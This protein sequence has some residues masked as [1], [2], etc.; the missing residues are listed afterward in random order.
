MRSI[1]LISLA[2]LGLVPASALAQQ[3]AAPQQPEAAPADSIVYSQSDSIPNF[4]DDA[5]M[6]DEFVVVTRKK[7]VKM[8]AEK[9]TY[10]ASQDPDAQSLSTLEI[11]R[12]VPMVSVDG[13][14]NITVNGKSDFRIYVN[15]KPNQMLS[16]DPGKMLKTI[17]ASTID[18]FEVINNPGAKYDAE[19]VGGI[20]N[21]VLKKT[22]SLDGFTATFT[23]TTGTTVQ[24]GSVYAMAQRDKVSLTANANVLHYS[25]HAMRSSSVRSDMSTGSVLTNDMRTK[26][27]FNS[28]SAS[29]TADYKP[30]DADYFAVSGSV[31]RS[32]FRLWSTGTTNMFAPSAAGAA[33]E[34][35]YG[36]GMV[37]NVRNLSVGVNA[38]A[39]Y[40]HTFRGNS[41]N[42]LQLAYRFSTNPSHSQAFNTFS[43]LANGEM[44]IPENYGTDFRTNMIEHI[45]QA[46]YSYPLGE[47]HIFGIGSKMTFRRSLSE[48]SGHR[49]RHHTTISAAYL[50]YGLKAGLFSLN[51][52]AR[53][54][55]TYQSSDAVAGHQAFHTDYDNFVPNLTLTY[56]FTPFRTLSAGY[57]MRISRPGIE[58]LDPFVN[59]DDPLAV[60]TGNPSLT[61]EKYHNL[62]LTYSSMWGGLMLNAQAG[63]SFSNDGLATLLTIRDGVTYTTYTNSMR[64]RQ[65]N[66]GLFLN[67]TLGLKT[68]IMLS[69]QTSFVSMR[70]PGTSQ[71]NHGWSQN[72]MGGLQQ[73]LPWDLQ[74]G[75]NLFAS[76][77]RK[78]LT[79][80]GPSFFM[81]MLSVSKSFLSD[82]LNLSLVVVNP[83]EDCSRLKIS[84]LGQNMRNNVTLKMDMRSVMFTVS[85]RIGSLKPRRAKTRDL[86]SDIAPAQGGIDSSTGMGGSGIPAGS[87][88]STTPGL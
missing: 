58:Y 43:A 20:L 45:G 54:E 53:W 7:L 17:P 39:D 1:L 11:L 42:L 65:F 72:I 35:L 61:A 13:Q 85:Y 83:F 50:T 2:V 73:T 14:D 30:T 57:N 22:G 62:N 46:D 34:L 82:R 16:S 88:P 29:L 76:T 37:N 69:S 32:P 67:Y 68:R 87:T 12:R 41:D 5:S 60:T 70:V 25:N 36:Y 55:H 80:D 26:N 52:G 48:D 63:Y 40:S 19:G 27:Q 31:N 33:S 8:D 9:L 86:D 15:G 44:Y 47:R 64:N 6:L 81:H 78:D 77:P 74:L 4:D 84:Q 23:G 75:V 51:A 38:S 3:R 49:F 21:I 56:A 10:D 71:A 28:F 79:I 66:L 18:H 24:Q 59:N